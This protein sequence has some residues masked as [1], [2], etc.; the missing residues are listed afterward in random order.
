MRLPFSDQKKRK[1]QRIRTI[2][3]LISISCFL[4]SFKICYYMLIATL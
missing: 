3:A 4:L 2:S 1:G